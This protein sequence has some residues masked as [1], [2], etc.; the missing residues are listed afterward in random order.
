MSR[1][2]TRRDLGPQFDTSAWGECTKMEAATAAAHA[3]TEGSQD[4]RQV[5]AQATLT[6]SQ[7]IHG[8]TQLPLAPYPAST[9]SLLGHAMEDY[10]FSPVGPSQTHLLATP[11][12]DFPG[13]DPATPPADLFLKLSDLIEREL[14]NTAA[15]ITRDIK[16]DFQNL[17]SRMEAIETNW[18]LQ[19]PERI[20][21]QPTFRPSRTS[22]KQP[23]PE[24]MTWKTGPED[25]TLESGAFLRPSRTFPLQSKSLSRI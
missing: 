13:Q 12:P 6:Y 22:L 14:A 10:T 25:I 19:Y 18:T 2:A 7:V 8:S 16:S 3:Y 21:I 4:Q 5:L 11:S 23:F 15:K 20:R 17:R 1:A 9:E 24:L